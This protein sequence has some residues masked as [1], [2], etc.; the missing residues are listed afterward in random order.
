VCE[1]PV[2]RKTQNVVDVFVPRLFVVVPFLSN[3]FTCNDFREFSS[4]ATLTASHPI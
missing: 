2:K 1:F 3:Y 4:R